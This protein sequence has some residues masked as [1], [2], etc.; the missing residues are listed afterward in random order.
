M[1]LELDHIF[2]MVDRLDQVARRLQRDGWPLDGGTIHEGEGTR[3]RRLLWPEHHLEL[4]WVT[5]QHEARASPLRLDRRADWRASGASPFGIGL[6][7]TLPE[8]LRDDFWLHEDGGARIWM[9]RDN[10]RAPERPLVFVVEAAGE[11]LERR[12]PR[13]GHAQLLAGWSGPML[14]EVRVSTPAACAPPEHSGPALIQTRGAPH[15]QLV[16]GTAARV[17]E[18]TPILSIRG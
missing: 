3:N 10:E 14:R 8:A 18:I 5:A 17:W 1:T 4:L 9:H 11:D 15:L 13:T 12:R 7:G 16:C 6:R 2:C